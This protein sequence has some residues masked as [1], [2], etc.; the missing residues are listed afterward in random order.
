MYG[1]PTDLEFPSYDPALAR[2]PGIPFSA[3][4]RDTIPVCQV[5]SLVLAQLAMG[6]STVNIREFSFP[7]FELRP[8]AH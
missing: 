5:L 3:V 2:Q 8:L 7:G 6:C 4:L 1:G